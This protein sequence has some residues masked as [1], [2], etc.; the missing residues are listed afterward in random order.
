[1][2]EYILFKTLFTRGI[3]LQYT[4]LRRYLCTVNRSSHVWLFATPWTIALSLLCPWNSPGRNTGVDCHFL[5]QRIFLT[6]GSNPGLLHWRQILYQLSCKGSQIT[7][8]RVF[9]ASW[10]WQLRGLDIANLYFVPALRSSWT[11][12][13]QHVFIII[14]VSLLFLLT[15]QVIQTRYSGVVL[16]CSLLM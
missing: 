1:M 9:I 7:R 14:L 8:Y 6:Q 16:G 10:G 15:P 13:S 5:L 12:E 3:L 11:S 4:E 2:F